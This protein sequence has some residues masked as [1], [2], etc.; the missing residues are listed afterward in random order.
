MMQLSNSAAILISGFI[1]LM[2]L[3]L[4]MTFPAAFLL[5]LGL[6]L[7]HI[8][9]YSLL[10]SVRKRESTQELIRLSSSLLI[11]VFALIFTL[12]AFGIILGAGYS[13]LIAALSFWISSTAFLL[14]YFALSPQA[15]TTPPSTKILIDLTCLEDGRLA[16]LAQTGLLDQKLLIPTYLPDELSKLAESA[17]EPQRTRARKALE[18]LHKI[19]SLPKLAPIFCSQPTPTDG[20]LTAKLIQTAK[21][22]NAYILTT[23]VPSTRLEGVNFISLD[24]IASAVKHGPQRGEIISIKIQRVG[25]EPRQGVGYL[26][27]GTMVVVNGAGDYLGKTITAQVLSQK[28]S[29]TG[30]I[31]FCNV[32]EESDTIVAHQ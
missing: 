4:N 3:Q 7:G 9:L 1:L 6:L 21:S 13:A 24:A 15:T 28:F 2:A 18:V 30:K 16:D 17:P 29:S 10:S 32:Q 19:E 14:S 25:K 31:I 22:L 11:A 23:E 20:D 5:T 12:I 27:D 8:F 26:D